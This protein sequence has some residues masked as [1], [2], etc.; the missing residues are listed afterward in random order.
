MS[1]ALYYSQ[2]HM[3]PNKAQQKAWRICIDFRVL[4]AVTTTIGQW[5]P[6]IGQLMVRV[7][8]VR[9][10]V[11]GVLD[12]TSGYYQAPLHPDS[13]IYTAFRCVAGM[14][15]LTRVP[16]GLKGALAYF[17]A[18]L[19]T[20]ILVGL[21]YSICELYI[22]DIIVYARTE[23]EFCVR[24]TAVL[25]RYRKHNITF[26]PKKVKLGLAKV[27]YVGHTID[28]TGLSFSRDKISEVADFPTPTTIKTVRTF[29]GLCNYFRDHVRNHSMIDR[30][31][32]NV[33]TEYDRTRKFNGTAEADLASK[34]LK[35]ECK[36]YFVDPSGF[37]V[38]ETD[39]S[40][41]EIGVYLYCKLPERHYP[42]A[43]LESWDH[44]G[45]MWSIT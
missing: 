4:N 3:T 41:Y 20:E 18:A 28:S 33:V 2:V 40:D 38:L 9:P 8:M 1:D 35:D 39:P 6:N 23:E 22:D 25:E 10:K 12:L 31:I 43:F 34:R 45:N 13:W 37:L 27:E 29:L 44:R 32:R 16:M 24:L 42:I 21:L 14:F 7:G 17:Q 36:L 15:H 11:F 5:I 19:A 26:N 30:E